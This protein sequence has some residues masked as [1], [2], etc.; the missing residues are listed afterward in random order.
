M[1]RVRPLFP[2]LLALSM[3]ASACT[4]GTQ[5]DESAL[6][7]KVESTKILAA[8]G[9]LITTL[10][11][12]ENREVVPIEQIPEHVRRAVVAI[13]DARFFTHHGLDAKAVLRALYVNATSGKVIEGGSTITQQLV[14]NTIEEVGR[15]KTLARKIREAS[16]AYRV[17]SAFSKDKILELYLNTV[18]FGE[19]AYGVQ[20]A[21]QTYFGK[22][23]KDL[24]LAEG[25]LLAG[26]IK[27]PVTYNPYTD[28]EAALQRRNRVLDR[29]LALRLSSSEDVAKAKG[30][31]IEVQGKIASFTYKSAYFIDYVTRLI[32][33]DPYKEFLELGES[34]SDRANFLFRGGLRIHTT[35]DP[36]MQAAAEEAIGKVLDHPDRDPSAAL[37]AIDP[38]TG[39]VKALVG[40]RDF[41]APQEQD[42][43]MVV[44][45]V[46]ADGS[47]KTCAKVNLA[48]G[49]NGG[50][51]GR[52][53]GSAFKPFVLAAALEKGKRLVDVYPAPSCISIPGADSGRPWRVCNYEEASFGG[54]MSVRDGTVKSVNTVYAQL[55]M[56]VGATP[57]INAAQRMGIESPLDAVP[58]A[59][60]GA[61]AVSPLEMAAA[62]TVFPNLGERLSPIA[63]TKITD[64][65][66]NDLWKPAQKRER[67]LNPAVS[68]L[69][70]QTLEE[71]IAR[72]TAARNG[73][74]GRPAFGKTGTSQ[75]WR[76]AWFVGGAGT[77]LVAAVAVFWPDGE[78]SMKPACGGARTTY[79][80]TDG[81]VATP[82]CR[83]TRIRVTGGSWPT[84]IW[85]IFMLN[86]LKD[87]PASTFPIP[88]VDRVRVAIDQTRGC[89]PNPYTPSELIR[90]I[91]FIK[92]TEPTE[93]CTEPSGP[94]GAKV[95][96]VVGFP[97]EQAT[98]LLEQAGFKVEKMLE[99]SSLYPPGR[100]VSQSPEAGTDVPFGSTATIRVS[101]VSGTEVPDV[102]NESERTARRVLES[103]GFKPKIVRET[104]CQSNDRDCF[105]W[106]QD[107]DGGTT[108]AD[109]SEVVI[110]VKRRPASDGSGSD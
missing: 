11:Q 63:I 33:H 109:G 55:I 6:S 38:K 36:H 93:V 75:E 82:T 99:F 85:Q 22:D 10:R 31:P 19:G 95:P 61:N 88:E 54:A 100:V 74:I 42:P 69:V 40:G 53:S 32:Q 23:I 12:E 62:F 8:D 98:K 45:A 57:V 76:D 52:Q 73:R 15:E 1:S 86:A 18:Y 49:R 80:V 21:S 78:I 84:Q 28:A 47:P 3:M 68:Y 59:A 89:L 94:Q 72:G 37:V 97:E 90:M 65:R 107:P 26:L 16:F 44:G 64:S 20:T 43:C 105:V 91:E 103:S 106:D 110:Y 13:E 83:P 70:T 87:I 50:G 96:G 104:G 2:G 108:A 35:L 34:V 29:M 60:L 30:T 71:V 77:D 66:G 25:A 4:L 17:D 101:A 79:A 41:F 46:N 7:P 58:S 39:Q 24:T 102:V 14:R 92:G 27:A 81:N 9:S 67:A 51:S 48:L 5:V 56:D